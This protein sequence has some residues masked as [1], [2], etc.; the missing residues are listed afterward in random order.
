MRKLSSPE[1]VSIPLR[2]PNLDENRKVKQTQNLR[3]NILPTQ[4]ERARASSQSFSV[5]NS[6]K[7]KSTMYRKS[8]GNS[9]SSSPLS[10]P[11][12]PQPIILGE[13]SS[14]RRISITSTS[15]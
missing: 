5:S 1:P 10:S 7:V 14:P 8:F 2:S 6:P 9:P 3:L 13:C 12:L 15:N 11:V 4:G